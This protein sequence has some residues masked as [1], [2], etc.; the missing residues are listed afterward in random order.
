MPVFTIFPTFPNGVVPSQMWGPIDDEPRLIWDVWWNPLREI[1][2]R[3]LL[4][5]SEQIE[6]MGHMRP[7]QQGQYFAHWW[8]EANLDND[9][10]QDRELQRTKTFTGMPSIRIQDAAMMVSMGPIRDR[11]QEHLGTTDAMVIKV[12]Q[13]LLKAAKALRANGTLPP[14]ADQPDLYRLRSCAAVLPADAD[15]REALDDWHKARA[16]EVLAA[17]TIAP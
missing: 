12:R 14:A 5:R 3:G 15:W 9:F 7:A 10:L 17:T 13:R 1:P 8:P 2:E 16:N 6:G 4:A 11:S